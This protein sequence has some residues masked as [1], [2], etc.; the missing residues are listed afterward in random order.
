MLR[1]SVE[2]NFGENAAACGIYNFSHFEL[3]LILKPTKAQKHL[4]IVLVVLKK[5]PF[6]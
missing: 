5:T 2:L 3:T 4:G 1:S 6:E